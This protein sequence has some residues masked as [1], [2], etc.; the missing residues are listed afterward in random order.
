[1]PVAWML[2]SDATEETVNFF[3]EKLQKRNPDVAPR[4]FMTDF[5]WPQI[6]SIRRQYPS[7]TVLLCWW[8]VLHAWQQ[9]FIPSHYPE[10]WTIL[11][12][13]VRDTNE[14]DFA[15]HWAQ[16]QS[17]APSS[18][19]DYFQKH[20]LPYRDLWSAIYR[21]NRHVFEL[22]DTNMLVEA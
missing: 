12:A 6:K 11:K 21:Q 4:Y 17:L 14:A 3:L 5:N 10:L 20:W 1:M 18:L 2:S 7:S 19:L 8:H 13:W 16:I 9:H 15:A 22:C